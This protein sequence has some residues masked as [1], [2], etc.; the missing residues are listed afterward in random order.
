MIATE[1]TDVNPSIAS[2]SLVERLIWLCESFPDLAMSTGAGYSG[3]VLL[4]AKRILGMRFPVY[5]IDTGFHFPETLDYLTIVQEEAGG[6][7]EILRSKHTEE[8]RELH[9]SNPDLCCRCNK[10]AVLAK[11]K[12]R[13]TV[14]LHA[15]RRDQNRYREKLSFARQD[16]EGR[17]LFYPL[18]DWTREDCL[19]FIRQHGI[20]MHPLFVKGYPSIGCAPCTTRVESGES[21]RAGRWRNAPGKLECGL[22]LV[23]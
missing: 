20:R 21:E 22:H 9:R 3:M 18:F 15:L 2:T 8:T 6:D 23:G 16:T 1:L 11:V 19:V 13:H 10:V 14:W 12:S 7:L 5:F 17:L 4:R